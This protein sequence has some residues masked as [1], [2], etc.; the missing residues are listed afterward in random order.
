MAYSPVQALTN[1]YSALQPPPIFCVTLI[2][3]ETIIAIV[4]ICLL[5]LAQILF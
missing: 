1:Y 4:G 2:Q 5:G 3:A